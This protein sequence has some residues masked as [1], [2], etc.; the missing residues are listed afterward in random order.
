MISY[1][2]DGLTKGRYWKDDDWTGTEGMIRNESGRFK[3]DGD[4][5]NE[6]SGL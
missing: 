6:S 2:I 5:A 4:I 3:G 1:P